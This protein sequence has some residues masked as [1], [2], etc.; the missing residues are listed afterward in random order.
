MA[1]EVSGL[2]HKRCPFCLLYFQ[3]KYRNQKYCTTRCGILFQR[4][5]QRNIERQLW[6]AM[7]YRCE[8]PKNKSWIYYGGRGIKVCARWR[9][10]FDNFFADMGPRPSRGLSIDRKNNDGDYT[11]AN[12]RWATS[13]EQNLNRSWFRQTTWRNPKTLTWKSPMG[14]LKTTVIFSRKRKAKS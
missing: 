1:H 2:N 10:S 9:T 12:C 4:N 5:K 11:P 14:T 13:Q 7:I 3:P 8:N 6:K